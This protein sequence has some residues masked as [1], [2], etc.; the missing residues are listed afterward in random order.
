MPAPEG[1]TSIWVRAVADPAFRDALIADPLRALAEA[2]DVVASPEQV[3]SSRTCTR[4][5]ATSW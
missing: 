3:T 4:R 2:G 1:L 5:S